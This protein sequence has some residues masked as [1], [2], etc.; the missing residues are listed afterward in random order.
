MENSSELI[1]QINHQL[2][3][4]EAIG[5]KSEMNYEDLRIALAHYLAVLLKENRTLL[6]AQLYRIDV[7]EKDVKMALENKN[8]EY[9]LAE[10]ILQKLNEKLYWRNKYKKA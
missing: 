6:Y 7:A 4:T 3:E 9:L 2:P 8:S 10:L 5:L 1:E